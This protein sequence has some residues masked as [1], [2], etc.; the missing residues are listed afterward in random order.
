M[1]PTYNLTLNSLPKKAAEISKI[2]KGGEVLALF[3]NLGA[4]KTTFTQYLAKHL[5]IKVR[6]T[7]PTFVL[8]NAFPAKLPKSK[9]NIILLHLDLYRIK[10]FKEAKALGITEMWQ[11]PDTVT[12]IEWADKIEKHLPPKT[13]KLKFNHE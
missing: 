12:V 13:W 7:S 8:M 10:N 3:G 6:V 2:L 5:G 1:R 11:R 9:K 4:G